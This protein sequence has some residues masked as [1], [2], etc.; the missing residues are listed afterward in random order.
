M[1]RIIILLPVPKRQRKLPVLYWVV[2]ALIIMLALADL[3]RSL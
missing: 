2:F 1:S 3:S